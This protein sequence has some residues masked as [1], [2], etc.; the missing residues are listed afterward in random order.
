MSTDGANKD[1]CGPGMASHG[2]LQN[3]EIDLC[4]MTRIE[5]AAGIERRGV[6]G[7]EL[8]PQSFQ[9]MKD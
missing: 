4:A 9:Y 2:Q 1:G 7:Q 8:Q 3:F 6:P 5:A